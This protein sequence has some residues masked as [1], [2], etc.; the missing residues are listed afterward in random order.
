[1]LADPISF[2]VATVAT[3]HPRISVGGESNVYSVADGSSQI[4]VGG[5]STRNRKRFYL[6]STKTKIAADPLTAVNQSVNASVTISIS[7]PLWGFTVAELK[8]LVL[9]AC[10]FLTATTGA[11]T[12]KILGGER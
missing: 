5:S 7:E 11:N 12:D 3:N 6:S 10:D 1:M 4:R 9:D 8:A 2:K